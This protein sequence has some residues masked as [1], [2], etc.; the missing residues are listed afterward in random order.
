MLK[1]LRMHAELNLHKLRS[2]R[3]IAGM[4]R[5]LDL[6]AAPTD[7]TTG[8][9]TVGA[10]GQLSIAGINQIRPTLYRYTTLIERAKQLVQLAGQIEAQMLTALEQRDTAAYNITKAQQDVRIAQAD[11]QLQSLRVSEA[12]DGV[13]LAALQ[14]G[15]AQIKADHYQKLLEQPYSVLE[16]EALNRLQEAI[17]YEEKAVSDYKDSLK[18]PFTISYSQGMSYGAAWGGSTSVTM[19][20]KDLAAANATWNAALAS[21]S[22]MTGQRLLSIASFERRKEEWQL[23]AALAQQDIVIGFQQIK[24]ANDQVS[25]AKQ[26]KNIAELR[27]THAE[28]IVEFLITKNMTVELCDWMIG[29]LAGVYRFFLQEATSMA[30]LAQGQLSF[31]RQ[32]AAPAVIQKNYW[33]VASE[34]GSNSMG[35]VEKA[36][37]RKGLTGSARLLQDIYQLDQYAFIN[38]QRK[39]QLTKRLSLTQLAPQE[40]QRFRES[41]VMNFA[42]PMEMF[43]RDFPGHYLRLIKR[44]RTSVIALIPPT[45][46]ISATLTSLG[47]SR[48]VIGPTIFQSVA[49]R[50]DPQFVA[51]TSPI[52]SSGVFE[53]EPASDE[54]LLPFEGN[55]VDTG[56]EFRMPKAAN[57]FDYR[58][59]ADVLVTIDYTALNS[60]EYRQQVIEALGTTLTA[61][62][63]FSFRNQ[64]ADQWYDLNNPERSNFPMRV[65]FNLV[66]DDF[67]P[68]VQ[69]IKIQQVLIYFV[70]SAGQLAEFPATKL[71]FIEAGSSGAVGGSATP[72]DGIISTRRGN[73]SSW[74]SMLGKSPVGE[75]ELSLPNTEEVRNLFKKEQIQD[76]LFVIT[77]S[78]RTPDWPE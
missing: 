76:I 58:S 9:P 8:I 15:S 77:Y 51:L 42:T 71:R 34:T 25:I 52:E 13:A 55:G 31:E 2:C 53:M 70:S 24:I 78:G 56:W 57:Q 68:N 38:N 64:L 61:D 47:V 26:E 21:A 28:A 19:S 3:N 45:R 5:E 62:R 69:S 32:E 74:M 33:I 67:P 37:D 73:G 6:Y 14:Q 36:V 30:S 59:I 1:A 49:I 12:T 29:I 27:T 75:W 44:V 41:G 35:A 46:G 40:F 66:R 16:L 60:Y 63:S 22:N 7:T 43:D 54:M 72:I 20:L 17:N 65:E 18:N 23:Q 48:T 39:L 11:V 50:R 4:K 10:A